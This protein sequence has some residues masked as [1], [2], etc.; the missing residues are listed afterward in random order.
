MANMNRMRF[1]V[2]CDETAS[3]SVF[4]EP[5]GA[6]VVLK[7]GNRLTVEISGGKAQPSRRSRTRREV[8]RFGRGRPRIRPFGIDPVASSMSEAALRCSFAAKQHRSRAPLRRER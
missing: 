5:E 8:L 3:C 1:T 6:E 4:F 2:E 7:D